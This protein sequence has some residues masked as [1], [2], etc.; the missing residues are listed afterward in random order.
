M[1]AK[2]AFMSKKKKPRGGRP[3]ASQSQKPRNVSLGFKVTTDEKQEWN[4]F[5]VKS[6]KPGPDAL[7]DAIRNPVVK[8]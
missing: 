4:D 7:M 3:F 6:G 8:P 2:S 1:D 5:R